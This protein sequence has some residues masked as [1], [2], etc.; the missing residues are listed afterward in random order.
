[1]QLKFN[2]MVLGLVLVALTGVDWAVIAFAL[3]GLDIVYAMGAMAALMVVAMVP[4]FL[5]A[6][7]PTVASIEGDM[8][9]IGRQRAHLGDVLRI[10][11]DAKTLAFA[12]RARDEAGFWVGAYGERALALPLRRIDG[13]RKAAQHF[14]A[15]VEMT[16]QSVPQLVTE[17]AAAPPPPV[18]PRR[19]GID[20]DLAVPPASAARA[21]FGRK[22]L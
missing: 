3:N 7:P 2:R 5:M 17:T 8:L 1:M 9:R 22:G 21:G 12:V 6:R 16:R 4:L 15:Q 18:R 19:D 11:V 20:P 13:G 10:S 14:V